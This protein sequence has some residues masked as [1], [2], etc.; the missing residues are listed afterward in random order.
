[1]ITCRIILQ[2]LGESVKK[3]NT[4]S[5]R[6]SSQNDE[7]LRK[8]CLN[9]KRIDWEK[10]KCNKKTKSNYY[11]DLWPRKKQ[12]P[13]FGVRGHHSLL[14]SLW[15]PWRDISEPAWRPPVDADDANKPAGRRRLGRQHASALRCSSRLLWGRSGT[16]TTKLI[17]L[18]HSCRKIMARFWCISLA[19]TCIFALSI[20]TYP[21][22]T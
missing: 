17:L 22:A 16:N 18:K 5:L 3:S 8:R 19:C 12:L 21:N 20:W 9:N 7:I 15:P 2:H 4:H 10:E 14:H 13:I 6:L 1:M 11:L